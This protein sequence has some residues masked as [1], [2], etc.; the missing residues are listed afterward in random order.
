MKKILAIIIVIFCLSIHT[1][2]QKVYKG[3]ITDSNENKK[4]EYVNIGLIGKDLGTVSNSNGEYSLLIDSIY[5]DTF[6]KFSHI[7]Y[8]DTIIS[9]T[10]FTQ[11]YVNNIVLRPKSIQLQEIS[12]SPTNCTIKNLGNNYKGETLKAGFKDNQKGSE[13]GVLL[14]FKK[15]SRLKTLSCNVANCTFDSLFL[16]LNIYELSESNDFNNILNEPIYIVQK[17]KEPKF[18]INADLEQYNIILKGKYLVA[19]EYYKDLG[20][21]ELLFSC[22]LFKGATTYTRKASQGEWKK[23]KA[24]KIGFNVTAQVKE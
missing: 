5:D 4:I 24:A 23:Q 8:N 13:C 6:I 7:S 14:D 19:I 20:E 10:D 16:R 11:N 9:F 3:K 1:Y 22:G 17:V 18:Q 15:E 12:V 21:G 2:S